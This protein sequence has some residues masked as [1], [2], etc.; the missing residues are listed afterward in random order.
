MINLNDSSVVLTLLLT[1]ARVGGLL[2][3]APVLGTRALPAKLRVFMSLVIALAVVGRVAQPV[4][5]PTGTVGLAIALVLEAAI[6]LAI[7]YAARLVFVG[8]EL[9][10]FHISQQMGISLAETIDPLTKESTDPVRS[11]YRITA[12]V[13]FLAIGGHRLLIS[14]LLGTFESVPVLS[15]PSGGA[16]PMLKS[17]TGLLASS[18]ALAIKVALPALAA[19]LMATVAMAIL[20]RTVP[21]MSFFSVGLPARALVG[22]LAL[23]VALAYLP[24]AMDAAW[25]VWMRNIEVL[26]TR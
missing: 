23:S 13:I 18:F 12:L 26:V 2:F 10:A 17:I 20:G 24:T 25:R 16:M 7:G 9:G 21:Q 11:L 5:L 14:S 3:V 8:V 22:M 6:G 4:S 1:G 19:L 15:I